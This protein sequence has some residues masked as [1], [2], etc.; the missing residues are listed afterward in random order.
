[1]PKLSGANMPDQHL[2]LDHIENNHVHGYQ[3]GFNINES[4]FNGIS[5]T[6]GINHTRN[7]GAVAQSLDFSK[8]KLGGGHNV[9]ST[10]DQ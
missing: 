8:G 10:Q 7:R 1:M 4:Q 6:K 9:F 2:R 3:G 5:S